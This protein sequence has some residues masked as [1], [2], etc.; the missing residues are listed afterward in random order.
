V[1]SSVQKEMAE[2]LKTEW[3][4]LWHDR[5][6]DKLRAEGIAKAD[7][8][9]LFVDKGTVIFATRNYRLPNLKE[10]LERHGVAGAERWIPADASVG[11]WGKFIRTAITSQKPLGKVKRA[12]QYTPERKQPQQ[13]KKGGRG[14]LH[15]WKD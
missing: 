5:I 15:F 3:K 8:P 2:E 12:Q 11:G 6:D 1:Q 14:W 10:I 7:Y 9:S 4:K 13:L